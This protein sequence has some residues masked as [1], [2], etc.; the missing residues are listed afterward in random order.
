[1]QKKIEEHNFFL[2]QSKKNTS[3]IWEGRNDWQ[4]YAK[5]YNEQNICN[6][7]GSATERNYVNESSSQS[8]LHLWRGKQEININATSGNVLQG[9]HFE[10]WSKME[11]WN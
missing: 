5:F 8:V 2:I 1:M 4:I 3:L 11:N 6:L 10:K 7:C 9:G